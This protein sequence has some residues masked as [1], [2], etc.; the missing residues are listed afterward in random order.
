MVGDDV[1]PILCKLTD[2][3]WEHKP[4]EQ[5]IQERVAELIN[6]GYSQKEIVDEI[7]KSKGYVSKCVKKA[8]ELGL[9]TISKTKSTQPK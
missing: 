7:G 1:N 8:T 5:S 2:S 6:D 3:G 4:L 9:I